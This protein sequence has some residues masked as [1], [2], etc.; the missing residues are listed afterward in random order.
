MLRAINSTGQG[1]VAWETTKDEGPFLCPLCRKA[2]D[3]KKEGI[4]GKI[5]H[6][7]HS[8][9]S[10]CTHGG[11]GETKEHQG[12]KQAI[13][14][15]LRALERQGEAGVSKCEIEDCARAVPL[16]PDVSFYQRDSSGIDRLIAVEVQ[17]SKMSEEDI[18]RR[19]AE[20]ERQGVPVIW[21][22]IDPIE[23]LDA[24]WLLN[25]YRRVAWQKSLHDKYNGHVYYWRQGV[26]VEDVRYVPKMLNRTRGGEYKYEVLLRSFG[27][28]L[29]TDPKWHS[30][31]PTSKKPT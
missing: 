3:H 28:L 26:E 18:A 22:F 21:V 1:K 14:E 12:C 31:L 23:E 4:D 27:K 20:Y 10:N 2:V 13:Y 25:E 8:V 6:F 11:D 17:R 29:I 5:A 7:A 19:T 16:R 9:N 15:S 30:R 24:D